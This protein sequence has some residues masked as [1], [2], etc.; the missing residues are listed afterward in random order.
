MPLPLGRTGRIG[1]ADIRSTR[2]TAHHAAAGRT[3]FTDT[4]RNSTQRSF[5]LCHGANLGDY[6]SRLIYP[7]GITDTDIQLVNKVLIME[8]RSV[9]LCSA[10]LY[11]VEYRC[12]SYPAGTADRQ[13]YI[14]DDRFLLL[15]RVLICH[16]PA[17]YLCGSADYFPVS[18]VIQ[19]H[20]RSIDIIGQL[21]AGS[22]YSLYSLPDLVSSPAD[23]IA[24]NDSDSLLLHKLIGSG[25]SSKFFSPHRLKVENEQRKMTLSRNP[26]V[27]LPQSA[28]R[29]VAGIGKLLQSQK[30]LTV[31][32]PFKS[33]PCH[34]DLASDF[35]I[36][37]LFFQRLHHIIY[38]P[39]ISGDILTHGDTVSSGDSRY[40]LAVFV[41]KRQRKSVYLLLYN[42]FRQISLIADY[43]RLI[44]LLIVL[45]NIF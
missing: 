6:F 1:T 31:I 12:W 17:R 36:L 35:Q 18:Q 27:K 16:R 39:G 15:R 23:P 30:L 7:H 10:E 28:C 44:N 13:L 21:R 45:V 4:E 38:H 5:L 20:H 34:V 19:L 25:M 26:T 40:Q 43:R 11:R 24:M 42:E 14:T 29:T 37:R 32:S 3:A 33:S 22:A 41:A 2:L 9:H 8:S